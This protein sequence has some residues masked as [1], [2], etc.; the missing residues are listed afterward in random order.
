MSEWLSPPQV[1]R[2]RGVKPAKVLVWI[3]RGE[4]EA[5]NHAA[6]A[7]G[8]PRWRISPEALAAFDRARTQL[9]DVLRRS[10]R[11]DQGR[12]EPRCVGRRHAEVET[13]RETRVELPRGPGI[14]VHDAGKR[15][16][17]RERGVGVEL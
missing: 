5:V 8:R 13:T 9:R 2:A 17:M 3:D 11:V 16:G 14:A 6:T 15:A 1:A 12:P 7:G 10:R 4:L